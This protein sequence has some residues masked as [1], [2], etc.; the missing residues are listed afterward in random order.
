MT[1]KRAEVR[2]FSGIAERCKK[3]NKPLICIVGCVGDNTEPLYDTG[4]AAIFSII[5]KPMDLSQSIENATE[6]YSAAAK[7]IFRVLK[8]NMFVR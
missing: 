1:A 5:N 7:N 2:S 4:V 3:F 8:T 6:L